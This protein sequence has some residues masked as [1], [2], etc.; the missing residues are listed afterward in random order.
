VAR[1]SRR[2]ND[3]LWAVDPLVVLED[4]RA[5]PLLQMLSTSEHKKIAKRASI[6]IRRLDK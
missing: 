1:R 6:A 3:R 5:R 2:A 4:E